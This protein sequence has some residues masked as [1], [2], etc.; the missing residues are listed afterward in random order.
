M[1]DTYVSGSPPMCAL[2]AR[3]MA[4]ATRRALSVPRHSAKSDG[5]DPERLQP[6]APAPAAA[7]LICASPGTSVTRL[8]IPTYRAFGADWSAELSAAVRNALT[9]ASTQGE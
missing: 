6:S 3:V 5:P 9:E 7:C 8:D 2:T 4:S 1:A